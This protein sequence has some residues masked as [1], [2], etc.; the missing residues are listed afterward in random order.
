[1]RI[2]RLL[3]TLAA[4][5]LL[6][7]VARAAD[8]WKRLHRPLHVPQANGA[9]P[10]TATKQLGKWTF[11]HAAPVYLQNVGSAPEPGTIDIS[12]SLVDATGWRGQ[13][14][15]WL[16]PAPYR[17]PVLIRGSRIDVS[18][19]MRF[20]KGYGDHLAELRFR[21]GESNGARS[22]IEGLPG[23]YR[24]LASSALF[25]SS[26]CYAFQ[27]DGLSFSVV[28]VVRVKG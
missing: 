2:V 7:P 10:T 12:Q 26:G 23:R 27:V 14:T 3:L 5:A 8:D 13:K 28:I 25:R 15:P 4:L 17:G 24:L 22:R 18:G 16:V 11:S 6:V 19:E 21:S 20:A 1:M 9:C